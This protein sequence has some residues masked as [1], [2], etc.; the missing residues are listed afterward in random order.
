MRSS[1]SSR[2]ITKQDQDNG[3]EFVLTLG[4]IRLTSQR[5]NKV[6]AAEIDISDVIQ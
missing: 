1:S 2:V 4:A 5:S 3:P 6:M